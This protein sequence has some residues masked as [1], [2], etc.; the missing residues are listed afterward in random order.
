MQ[1]VFVI[2]GMG[3]GKSTVTE[4]FAEKGAPTLDLDVIG[5]EVLVFPD[6]KSALAQA[7][8][9]EIFD[10]SGDVVRS[11]LAKKAFAS[12]HATEQ[13]NAISMPR[14]VQRL[15]AL[16]DEFEVQDEPLVVVEVSAYEGPQGWFGGLADIVIA[17]CA[18]EQTRIDRAVAKGFKEEDVRHR[19]AQQA[20]DED[21]R[22]WADIVI[23]NEGDVDAL[24][25]RASQV[26]S[27][28]SAR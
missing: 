1:T 17:V 7:F 26:W 12:A 5:H 6:T 20:H 21:R 3:S 16:L 22:V 10:A 27:Y 23:D 8:G 25:T 11:A 19:L 24:R 13:L 28:L 18:P 9:H 4:V 15:K 2:G 14:I